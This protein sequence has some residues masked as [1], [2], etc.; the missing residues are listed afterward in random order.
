M[1][2]KYKE[3]QKENTA[4]AKYKWQGGDSNH[5]NISYSITS[6]LLITKEF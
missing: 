2:Y 4:R 6:K 5:V 3:D 1:A